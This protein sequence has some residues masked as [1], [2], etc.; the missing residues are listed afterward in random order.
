MYEIL[1]ICIVIRGSLTDQR[2]VDEVL[3]PHVLQMYQT[4]GNNFSSSQTVPVYLQFGKELFASW[5]WHTT[6]TGLSGPDPSPISHPWDILGLWIH[7]CI[8]LQ[9]PHFPNLNTSWLNSGN[10]FH[11]GVGYNPRLLKSKCKN[12]IE[13]IYKGGCHTRYGLH[14][15]NL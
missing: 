9:L 8:S 6:L 7:D 13:C 2:Y 15:I 14:C 11:K 10:V 12:L 5:S 4:G 3:H 1:L